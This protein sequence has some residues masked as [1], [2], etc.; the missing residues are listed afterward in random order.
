[1]NPFNQS[2]EASVTDGAAAAPS[3][4][5]MFPV[6]FLGSQQVLT[7]RGTVQL[8]ALLFLAVA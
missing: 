3:D 6:R 2:Q 7:D 4:G 8:V 1:V 5:S